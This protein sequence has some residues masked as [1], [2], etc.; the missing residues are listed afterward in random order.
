M[1]RHEF[2][3]TKSLEEIEKDI[4]NR[5]EKLIKSN[6]KETYR[7]KIKE[8]KVKKDQVH[9]KIIPE[10]KIK[11]KKQERINNQ[12]EK[13]SFTNYFKNFKTKFEKTNKIGKKVYLEENGKKIGVISDQIFDIKGKLKGL[14][15]KDKEN[16]SEFIYPIDR[17]EDDKTGIFLKPKWYVQADKKIKE[18]GFIDKTVPE[19]SNI[20]ID[21]D[22][23]WDMFSFISNR[24]EEFEK[25]FEET[26][27]IYQ[28]LEKQIKIY[29][30]KRSELKEMV[31]DITTN[32]LI[33]DVDRKK[34]SNKIEEAR[35]KA[36][37]LNLNI[38]RCNFLKKTLDKTSIGKIAK[39]LDLK[40]EKKNDK[41]TN[42]DQI[43]RLL[44]D[45]LEEKITKD[46]KKYLL[47]SF[48]NKKK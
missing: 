5:Y 39:N 16:N 37:I 33:D 42:N 26:R 22:F 31:W 30:Q 46:I 47:E 28:N 20:L 12:K 1:D 36:N 38:K 24:D 11:N 43:D 40:N 25:Y 41:V 10:T 3:K 21:E 8:T 44:A 13:K 27:K 18:I 34:Y 17:F 6:N 2:N 14:K 29:E 4:E 9:K 35:K 15:I 45:L 7:E 32:R 19:L 23:D 48:Q